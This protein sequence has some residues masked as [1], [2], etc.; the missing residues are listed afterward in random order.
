MPH[1]GLLPSKALQ[2]FAK[3]QTYTPTESPVRRAVVVLAS[4]ILVWIV[5]ASL[6]PPR[7]IPTTTADRSRWMTYSDTE[8]GWSLRYPPEWEAR[9]DED[10]YPSHPQVVIVNFRGDLHHSQGDFWNLRELPPGFVL[11]EME[12]PFDVTPGPR[13]SQRSTPLSL[14]KG[15]PAQGKLYEGAAWGRLLPVYIQGVG[16]YIVRAYF[17]PEAS[18]MDQRAAREIMAS[19]RLEG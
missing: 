4:A 10:A 9:I 12:V 19:I 14:T 17:G 6:T 2:P 5:L 11:V 15:Y 8:V 3:P 7:L 13:G 18:L 1:W 16:A